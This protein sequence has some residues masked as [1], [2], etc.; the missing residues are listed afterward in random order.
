MTKFLTKKMNEE[1]INDLENLAN[2]LLTNIV[3]CHIN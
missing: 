2:L 1:I 3:I